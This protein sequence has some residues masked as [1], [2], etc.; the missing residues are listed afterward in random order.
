MQELLAL[1]DK[2]KAFFSHP[3]LATSTL[4][5]LAFP[6]FKIH[7]L[8]FVAL[9][10]WLLG[11]RK[12]SINP[13]KSGL[14]LGFIFFG[15]QMFWLVLFVGKWTGSYFMGTV[16]WIVASVLL[17]PYF[18]L[19]GWFF[20]RAYRL[21]VP[22][23]IPFIWAS[24]EMVRS[25]IPGLAFPHAMLATPF[26]PYPQL[27]QSAAF[28]TVFLVSAWIVLA[29]CMIVEASE[30]ASI[31]STMIALAGFI[32][33]MSAGLNRFGEPIVGTK[34]V[35][36]VAQLGTD[37]AFGDPRTEPARIASAMEEISAS[38]ILQQPDLIVLPEGL[39]KTV[40]SNPPMV[41]FPLSQTPTL[42]GLQRG[43]GPVYQ[44]A[45]LISG[46]ESKF[47]DKTRLVIFGEYVPFRDQ[48]SFLSSF[49]L[50]SGDLRPGDKIELIESG[51]IKIGPSICFE[52]LFPDIAMQHSKLGA[53]LLAV[54]SIDDWFIGTP[55]MEHL[56]AGSVYRAIENGLPVV[57]S[58]SMG[59]TC[60]IDSRG[61]IRSQAP[62]GKTLL[63]R[64]EVTLPTQ[65]P[66][67]YR[68]VFPILAFLVTGLTLIAP[69]FKRS[70][71][72]A[73]EEKRK[74]Y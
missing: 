8:L 36:S 40:E 49:N 29:N 20:N 55:M 28:G 12:Q 69:S 65:G 61:N 39:G 34:K 54:M 30:K 22:Y 17:M 23:A 10:P 48:L 24:V 42:F 57:R 37:L 38:A 66:L 63:L 1:L 58:S 3:V 68:E 31:R 70:P 44:S 16:P 60:W 19:L 6:P 33:V 41:P 45:F 56:L 15:A 21:G 32:L 50:P 73:S 71:A 52:A 18:A 47:V 13:V 43:A 11:I 35:I 74:E 27:A 51:E 72:K 46:P 67:P 59:P 4:L 62:I 7:L 5:I 25:F 53:N 26:A 14:T 2:V 9:V 64:G